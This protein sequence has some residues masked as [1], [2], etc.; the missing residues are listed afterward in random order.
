MPIAPVPCESVIRKSCTCFMYEQGTL[1]IRDATCQPTERAGPPRPLALTQ[2]LRYVYWR[3][4]TPTAKRVSRTSDSKSPN[5]RPCA[6]VAMH[7]LTGSSCSSSSAFAS[8]STSLDT[9]KCGLTILCALPWMWMCYRGA[10]ALPP[11]PPG[12]KMWCPRCV[13]GK[14]VNTGPP[15]PNPKPNTRTTFPSYPQPSRPA[16]ANLTHHRNWSLVLILGTHS[17]QITCFK[18]EYVATLVARVHRT[19]LTAFLVRPDQSRPEPSTH[20]H[21]EQCNSHVTAVHRQT[22]RTST[23]TTTVIDT[24]IG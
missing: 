13:L 23:A 1:S 19:P 7:S 20:L 10:A 4:T 5:P 2:L 6:S 21:A 8:T 11:G 15:L 14:K 24:A 17:P 16:Q 3:C 12:R 18:P 22:N 9:N